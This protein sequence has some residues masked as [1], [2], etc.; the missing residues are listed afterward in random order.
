[1]RHLAGFHFSQARLQDFNDCPRRFYLR[2]IQQ[3]AWPAVEAEPILENERFMEQGATFHRMIHQ[4]L[5]GIPADRLA[6]YATGEELSRWW[7][8]FC[9]FCP[10]LKTPQIISLPEHGL[11]AMLERFR[12]TA[13][14]DLIQ[15]H[16]DGR[17]VIYDW[18]TSRRRPRRAWLV[19]R[20]QTRLYS[21]LL[22]L[23]GGK[24]SAKGNRKPEEIAGEDIEMI[25]WFAGFPDQPERIPYSARQFESDRRYLLGLLEQI[26]RL[27]GQNDEAAFALTA[28]ETRCRFCIYR[29]LCARGASAGDLADAEDEAEWEEN[30]AGLDFDLEQIGE[31]AF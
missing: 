26:E 14:Y 28:D 20:L 4:S 31:I 30:G 10:A 29:S 24:L 8:N 3:L 1:M 22:A 6:A 21:F 16:K 11:S 25:Y 23:A 12:L 7:D 15:A 19:E 13:N 17:L 5:L 27:A 9:H 18:K 2:Y